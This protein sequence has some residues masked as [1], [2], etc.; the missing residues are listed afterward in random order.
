M[1]TLADVFDDNEWWGRP[2]LGPI[3]FETHQVLEQ[4]RIEGE[5][6]ERERARKARELLVARREV[7]QLEDL[8][9]RARKRLAAIERPLTMFD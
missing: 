3:T 1:S 2:A 7:S 8:L 4:V 5:R 6:L 9:D